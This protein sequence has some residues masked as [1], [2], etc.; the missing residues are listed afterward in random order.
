MI[1]IS[2]QTFENLNYTDIDDTVSKTL[3][4][5]FHKIWVTFMLLD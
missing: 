3:L 2:E 4:K 5:Y 1:D